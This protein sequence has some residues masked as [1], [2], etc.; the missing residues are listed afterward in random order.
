MLRLIFH[1]ATLLVALSVNLGR[2]SLLPCL[3]GYYLR[4]SIRITLLL[5]EVDLLSF[6]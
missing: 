4:D 5:S 2:I 3:L 1:F 6:H